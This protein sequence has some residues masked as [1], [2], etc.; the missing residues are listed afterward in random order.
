MY[1][2][3]CYNLIWSCPASGTP[4]KFA[5]INRLR[6]PA[7]KMFRW[8]QMKISSPLPC[9]LDKHK[10]CSTA[11][12]YKLCFL[13]ISWTPRDNC[14]MISELN[15]QILTAFVVYSRRGLSPDFASYIWPNNNISLLA[16]IV[17]IY[18]FASQISGLLYRKRVP[19]PHMFWLLAGC[20]TLSLCLTK[21][22]CHSP[23]LAGYCTQFRQ[24]L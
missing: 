24:R 6:L 5:I 1:N 4:A 15:P 8:V 18:R 16:V 20:S 22:R 13:M 17:F 2:K 9:Q 23:Q 10:I 21:E 19:Q 7:K 3:K 12:R 14:K 11:P